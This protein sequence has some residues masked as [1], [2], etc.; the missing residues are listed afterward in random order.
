[1]MKGIVSSPHATIVYPLSH[2][3]E[4]SRVDIT[5]KIICGGSKLYSFRTR[6]KKMKDT[7]IA[8]VVMTGGVMFT[9]EG[10][11]SP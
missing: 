11:L 8:A 6:S 4:M 9:I 2:M 1:M 10:V 3:M 5:P 7:N